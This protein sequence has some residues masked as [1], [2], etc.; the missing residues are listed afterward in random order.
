ML[1]YTECNLHFQLNKIKNLVVTIQLRL[2]MMV[3]K[4]IL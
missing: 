1:Y 4:N 3:L 2:I